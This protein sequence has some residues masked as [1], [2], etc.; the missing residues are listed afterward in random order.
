MHEQ[1]FIRLK[2]RRDGPD[3]RSNDGLSSG[4]CFRTNLQPALF[5]VVID[6][7]LFWRTRS[8]CNA[9]WAGVWF[10]HGG[11]CSSAASSATFSQAVEPGDRSADRRFGD[12]G[13]VRR[14]VVGVV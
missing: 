14:G 5:N 8:R 9:L 3:Y 7:P 12:N 13:S 6:P 4:P 1:P 10:R 11:F 2:M